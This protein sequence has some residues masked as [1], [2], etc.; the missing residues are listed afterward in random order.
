M[1]WSRGTWI[2]RRLRI[3]RVAVPSILAR[4]LEPLNPLINRPDV[5]DILINGPGECWCEIQG[6]GMEC[7][8]VP[9]LDEATLVRLVQQVAAF[10]YQGVNRAHPMLAAR[11][12][13]GGRLQAVLSPATRSPVALA[14]RKHGQSERALSDYVA[15]EAFE[16][17]AGE[18]QTRGQL[19]ETIRAMVQNGGAA[20][21]LELAVQS[22][23]NVLIS[24]GTGS[25]KT[26]FLG[27]LLRAIPPSERLILI[28]D[29]PEL[30]MT[31]ANSVAM[32]ACGHELGEA[33]LDSRDLLAAALRMRPDRIILGE[34]RGG[35]AFTF[36][37]SVNSGHPGS[38]S[39]LHAN[40][41]NSAIEQ[42]VL[43]TLQAGTN[44]K[45]DDIRHYVL[46]TV[47]I[48]VQ[49]TRHEGRR[50][51]SECRVREEMV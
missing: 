32:L 20:A 22:R 48:F 19:R 27:A 40:D 16:G 15:D 2:S 39:T 17:L 8:T 45:R 5:T 3:E 31:H 29:T 11:L 43:M 44:L 10:N 1:F 7:H 37:R 30:P 23:C 50:T 35:E 51:I 46:N 4:Y 26:T 18:T 47:D 33:Q 6:G 38:M 21:A 9:A 34:L 42:M 36:L 13:N 14:I 12:P 25:G 41:T 24:G 28:E 49:L